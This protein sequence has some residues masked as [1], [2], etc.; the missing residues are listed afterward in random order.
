MYLY[1]YVNIYS[2]TDTFVFNTF[3]FL[4][5]KD[6]IY[7]IY[8]NQDRVYNEISPIL[9]FVSLTPTWFFTK[10]ID[11]CASSA[12]GVSE[13]CN[14]RGELENTNSLCTSSLLRKSYNASLRD[15][16]GYTRY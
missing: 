8:F 14:W 7:I 12:G 6:L 3:Y 1:I 4:C 13:A 9:S 11:F 5:I 15:F 16:S 2:E 10:N